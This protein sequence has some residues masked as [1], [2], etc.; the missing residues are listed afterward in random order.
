MNRSTRTSTIT[1]TVFRIGCSTARRA[2]RSPPRI[3]R[4]TPRTRFDVPALGTV[5]GLGGVSDDEWRSFDA[6][7][8]KALG[9]AALQPAEAIEGAPRLRRGSAPRPVAAEPGAAAVGKDAARGERA[10]AGALEVPGNVKLSDVAFGASPAG[11]SATIL[12]RNRGSLAQIGWNGYP[13]PSAGEPNPAWRTDDEFGTDEPESRRRHAGARAR[14]GEHR[15]DRSRARTW[16]GPALRRGFGGA[17][18]EVHFTAPGVGLPG[19]SIRMARASTVVSLP[20][21]R[22][23]PRSPCEHCASSTGLRSCSSWMARDRYRTRCAYSGRSI[24]WPE[25]RIP[26]SARA[27]AKNPESAV[28]DFALEPSA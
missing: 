12:M 20:A 8:A 15:P 26:G 28:L 2:P 14:A 18:P 19:S 22:H 23:S 24:V 21:P 10:S 13:P 11:E 5:E 1:C 25:T 3:P 6:L 17:A 9:P 27:G 16:N 7:E 4:R